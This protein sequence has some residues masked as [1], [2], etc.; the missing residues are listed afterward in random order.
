MQCPESVL[1]LLQNNHEVH[2]I[3]GMLPESAETN[4]GRAEPYLFDTGLISHAQ[5]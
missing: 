4:P 3:S 2:A 5:S 1:T